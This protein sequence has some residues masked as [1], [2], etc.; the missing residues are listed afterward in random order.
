MH[1]ASDNVRRAEETA[2][3]ESSFVEEKR[4]FVTVG[5]DLPFDRLVRSLD[6]WSPRQ[7]RYKIFAQIGESQY[8]PKHIE[9][10]KF[11]EPP[12]FVK[13]F[14]EADLVVSHAGMGTILSSLKYQKPL[15]VLPR[16]AAKGEH[17]N[18]HQLAT[19]RHLKLLNKVNVAE[20]ET[21]LLNI[22]ESPEGLKVKEPIGDFASEPLIRKIRDF[23]REN[24]RGLSSSR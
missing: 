14:T 7:S 23:I 22:L 6:D 19:A 11:L 17:R 24:K 3:G 1:R 13:R 15:L 18:E 8:V 12:E 2:E 4:L 20:D 10:D 5:T 16:I 9:Y 21:D